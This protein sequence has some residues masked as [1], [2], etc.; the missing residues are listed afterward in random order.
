MTR[1]TSQIPGKQNK[2]TK[3]QLALYSQI[4]LS[5]ALKVNAINSQTISLREKLANVIPSTT[6][7]THGIHNFYPAKF[8]PQVPRYVIEKYRLRKKIILD[9]F[10]GS[11]TTALE[12]MI[13]G[14]S[15]ISSDINPM[16]PFLIDV[17]MLKLD[18]S[19]EMEYFKA[20]SH[21]AD[22]IFNNDKE[23]EPRWS[24]VDYW[25][26]SDILHRIK[27]MWAYI[28]SIDEN[29]E[30]EIKTIIKAAGLYISRKYSFGD[31]ETPKLTQ[32]R[33]KKA[34]MEKLVDSLNNHGRSVLIKELKS[35]SFEYLKSCL[36]LNNRH[37]LNFSKISRLNIVS[38]PFLY[39]TNKSIDLLPITIQPDTID[40]IVTS[41]P[42]L[43]AQ[44]YFRSTKIDLYWLDLL[45]DLQVK[46]L[47]KNEIGQKKTMFSGNDGRIINIRSYESALER[48][49]DLSVNFK[50][51]DNIQRFVSY[52]TDMQF[53]IRFAEEVL[54]TDGIL[55][56]FIGEP[57]VFGHPIS[58]KDIIIEIMIDCGF[59]IEETLFDLIKNRNLS[60]NRLN[61]NP[62][63]IAGEWLIVGRKP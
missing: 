62:E 57:K 22:I 10:A 49:I 9:P 20:I 36:E 28:H 43:Y 16:T 11:G 5:E 35:R 53:F 59:K 17:K 18:T 42:Y 61:E 33:F 47:T 40:C 34:R 56:I 15:N 14:N 38:Q 41:P 37:K 58:V 24:N 30:P 31:D 39:V 1:Y 48:I 55:S 7:L 25:Y 6:Y 50:T 29:V 19:K 60:K 45:S 13:T 12:S 21:H 32:S 8:I 26:R 3:E 27:Q 52:F 51:Q 4:D 54:K 44:E 23:F 2:A 46:N 63:G